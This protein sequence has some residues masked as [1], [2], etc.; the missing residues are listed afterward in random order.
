ML[1]NDRRVFDF[2]RSQPGLRN[3]SIRRGEWRGGQYSL[4]CVIQCL[5][6]L[7]IHT[8]EIVSD[9]SQRS[10]VKIVTYVKRK[11]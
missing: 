3:A 1:L 11:T 8:V 7:E 9:V 2:G 10:S 5:K 6:E 4:H